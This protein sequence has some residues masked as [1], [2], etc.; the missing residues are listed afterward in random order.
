M[1]LPPLGLILERGNRTKRGKKERQVRRDKTQTQM[2]LQDSR[3]KTQ[4][5]MNYKN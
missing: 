3:D 4:T 2:K 5:Q 1:P